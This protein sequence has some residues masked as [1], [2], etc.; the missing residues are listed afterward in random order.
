[1]ADRRVPVA[2]ESS[3]RLP[4]L[5]PYCDRQTIVHFDLDMT[6]VLVGDYDTDEHNILP[7]A[8]IADLGLCEPFDGHGW[9]A[10]DHLWSCRRQGKRT[11]YT[12]EQFTEEWDHFKDNPRDSGAKVAGNYN[13]WTNL[14]QLGIV[15]YGLITLHEFEA[16]PIPTFAEIRY[17]DR[18]RKEVWGY[19]MDLL[20]CPYS[21]FDFDLVNV[22]AACLCH[23]PAD[24]PDMH[25]LER[26][27][28]SKVGAQPVDGHGSQFVR[29]W[30]R[31]YFEGVPPPSYKKMPSGRERLE[32]YRKRIPGFDFPDSGV[33]PGV[34]FIPA[35][36]VQSRVLD[37]DDVQKAR[38]DEYRQKN[39]LPPIDYQVLA[40]APAPAPAP[41][42][43][44][45]G[46]QHGAW[47][48]GPPGQQPGAQAG[49]GQG[50]MAANWRAQQQPAPQGGR[51]QQPQA[52]AGRGR[53]QQPGGFQQAGRGWRGG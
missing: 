46:Q 8:K 10:S 41:A 49:R 45:R 27:I 18:S 31:K 23:D 32:I 13:W 14:Y 25:D 37:L 4:K 50:H 43:A 40:P 19:G 48:A 2:S 38:L 9:G 12:P 24:R 11:I 33:N 30:G 28:E 44:G 39:G 35:A 20:H 52:P 47:A 1:M 7:I 34:P 3:L 16:G 36:A 21:N 51:G 42:Q 6:N 5:T 53:G 29:E 17:P 26:L 22:V 15:M